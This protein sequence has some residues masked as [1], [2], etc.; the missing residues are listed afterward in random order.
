[1][2]IHTLA[3]VCTV[4]VLINYL[5]LF[6]LIIRREQIDDDARAIRILT[7]RYIEEEDNGQ[8][9]ERKFRWKHLNNV[10]NNDDQVQNADQEADTAYHQSDDE[11]EAEWRRI[12]YER[13][14][15]LKQ[16]ISDSETVNERIF[17]SCELFTSSDEIMFIGQLIERTLEVSSVN[18]SDSTEQQSVTTSFASVKRISITKPIASAIHKTTSPFLINKCDMSMAH[19]SRKSFLNRDSP[20]LEKLASL[21]KTDNDGETILNTAKGKGNYVFVATEKKDVSYLCSLQSISVLIRDPVTNITIDVL[22]Y[23]RLRSENPTPVQRTLA[24]W[25]RAKSQKLIWKKV[26]H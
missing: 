8:E 6:I 2:G 22:I 10:D 12:R 7:E 5:L 20:I 23:C 11:N 9:R 17:W 15:L 19:L 16:Q 26:Q 13:E 4:Y 14:Q 21:S 3:H 1:M 18:K 25:I 24:Q